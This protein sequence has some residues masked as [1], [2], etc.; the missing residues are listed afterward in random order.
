MFSCPVAIK[1]YIIGMNTFATTLGF[2]FSGASLHFFVYI[3]CF[4]SGFPHGESFSSATFEAEV[5]LSLVVFQSKVLKSMRCASSLI[6]AKGI[7]WFAEN[8]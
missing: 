5:P 3:I 4:L 8:R 2:C 1:L 6:R 7:I